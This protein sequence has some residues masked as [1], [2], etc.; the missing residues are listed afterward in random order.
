MNCLQYVRVK[1]L[2]PNPVL[3][4]AAIVLVGLSG[5]IELVPGIESVPGIEPEFESGCVSWSVLVPGWLFVWPA[6]LP[7]KKLLLLL[8][9][10]WCLLQC[11]ALGNLLAVEQPKMNRRWTAEDE[12]P[13][14]NSP[15]V[16]TGCHITDTTRRINTPLN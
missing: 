3:C 13:K 15:A 9:H 5:L 4:S 16:P 6:G 2:Q 7:S 10:P 14:M 1:M 8:L 11:P 12:Q